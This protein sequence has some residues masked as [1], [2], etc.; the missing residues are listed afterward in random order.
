MNNFSFG[1]GNGSLSESDSV[2]AST[3]ATVEAGTVAFSFS[4]SAGLG[5]TFSNGDQQ[6]SP[7]GFAILN[8]Q[9]NQYGTF[10]YLLGFND[11]YASDADYDDFVVGVKFASMTPV[12]EL[13]T[14]AMLLAGLG[15]F[16]LSARRRKDDFL[17]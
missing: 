8:G 1:M 11:S 13:Q 14:Y 4:D 6:Q 3:S 2:G 9:T 16:G 10:D 17:N 15:L 12:P 5:H 7:F